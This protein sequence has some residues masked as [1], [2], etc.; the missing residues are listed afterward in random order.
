MN[1]YDRD[2]NMNEVGDD[3]SGCEVDGGEKSYD[4]GSERIG[5]R[6]RCSLL[7]VNCLEVVLH[8]WTAPQ[9]W[10]YC[11][12]CL[13]SHP[14]SVGYCRH[15]RPDYFRLDRRYDGSST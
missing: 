10:N 6:H 8:D 12:C 9:S 5:A 3:E 15:C 13:S 11:H 14:L 2:Y 1:Y 4:C 7:R